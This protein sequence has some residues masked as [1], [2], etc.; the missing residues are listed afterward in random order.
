MDI[1]DLSFKR[2]VVAKKSIDVFVEALFKK[3][4]AL[5]KLESQNIMHNVKNRD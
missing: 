2:K 4:E 5:K 1:S 3:K